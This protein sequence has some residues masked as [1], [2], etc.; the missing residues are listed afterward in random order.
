MTS[1]T[2]PHANQAPTNS[3]TAVRSRRGSV[4]HI[5]R[6][7][8]QHPRASRAPIMACPSPRPGPSRCPVPPA[9]GRAAHW[10]PRRKRAAGAHT[11]HGPRRSRSGSAPAPSRPARRGRLACPWSG[12]A[13][14]A[15]SSPRPGPS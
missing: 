1:T 3:T 4:R 10:P 9:A 14:R 2:A 8:S 5:F 15:R 11:R 12:C 13:R 6:Y 7:S